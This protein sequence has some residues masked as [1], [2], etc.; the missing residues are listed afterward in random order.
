MNLKEWHRSVQIFNAI[1]SP[2]FSVLRNSA[3][4]FI[5]RLIS[6]SCSRDRPIAHSVLTQSS[7]PTLSGSLE[8][9]LRKAKP[10]KS[11]PPFLQIQSRRSFLLAKNYYGAILLAFW[12]LIIGRAY[13]RK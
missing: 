6:L 9:R 5:S 8:G 3:R 12:V 11:L 4:L 1:S 10:E 7:D 13:S 2:T